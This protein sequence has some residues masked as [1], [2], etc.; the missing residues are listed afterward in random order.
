[1]LSNK[2]SKARKGKVQLINAVDLYQ[3]MRKSLGSKR[4][5]IGDEDIALI[6][7]T[8]GAFDPVET[9]SLTREEEA[10]CTRGRPSTKKAEK[11]VF[12]CKIFRSHEFG[13]RR[14]TI[15]R[16]LRL[17]IQFTDE[18]IDTLRFDPGALNAPMQKLYELYGKTWTDKTYGDLEDV[19]A[20]ARALVKADFSDLKEKQ[21]KDLLDAK[22][23]KTQKEL[24][25]KALKLQKVIGKKQT[26]DFNAFEE[27]LEAALKKSGVKL[28]AKER[29]QL[30]D[31][32]TWTNPDAEPVIKKVVKGKP[33]PLYGTF[34]YQGQ[35]VEFQPD[36]NLRDNE[37]VPL[38]AKTAKGGNVD[39]ENE[40]YFQ[41]EVAPHVKDAW[42]DASKVDERD[43]CVGIVGYEIPFNRHF[44]QYEPPRDLAEIDADLDVLSG[45]IMAMLREVHS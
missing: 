26:D 15:E 11:R 45:E 20:E 18:R 4:Q 24:R 33:K 34:E 2:K 43:Q 8:F 38:T 32:V 5:Y 31:A 30:L 23:W 37:D 17:S 7:R 13:Y 40:A 3:K 14:I 22:V 19:E 44:Y 42:I 41:R 25:E 35:T 21:L 1:M 27:T 16:P 6:T 39:A 36:S 10:T 29:K 9:Y 28:E 12:G